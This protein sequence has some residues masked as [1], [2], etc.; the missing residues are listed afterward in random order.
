[1]FLLS[2]MDALDSEESDDDFD[3]NIEIITD[4]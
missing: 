3:G 2:Y 4:D 1:M